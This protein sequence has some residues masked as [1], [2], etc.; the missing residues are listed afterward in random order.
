MY[1]VDLNQFS[2][3]YKARSPTNLFLK[4]A[5]SSCYFSLILHEDVI[6]FQIFVFA[7]HFTI[8]FMSQVNTAEL[9]LRKDLNK[10]MV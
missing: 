7:S 6:V 2:F 4:T 8:L 10:G 5:A 9:N 1:A 3:M